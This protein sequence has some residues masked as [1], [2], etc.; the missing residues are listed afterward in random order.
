MTVNSTD[1]LKWREVYS[2]GFLNVAVAISWIAYHEYQPILMT[3][4]GITHLVDFML[5][6]KAIVLVI[7]PPVAGLIADYILKKNGKY[8]IVFTV[9]IGATAMVFMVVASLISSAH[10]MDMR[11]ILPVMIV[12]WLICMNLFVSPANSMIEAFAPVK[13]LP[14]VMG[15]LF[16]VTELVYALEPVIVSLVL[17]FGDTLTF[18]VGGV[19]I[20]VSGY[21]FH[22]VSRDEVLER[23]SQLLV[24]DRVSGKQ[25]IIS[26]LSILIIGLFLGI[27]KAF[28]IEFIPHHI[29]NKFPEFGEYGGYVSF[30][31]LGLCAIGGFLVSRK[32]AQLQLSKVIATSFVILTVGVMFLLFSPSIEL[33]LGGILI[34]AVGFTL[35]NISGLPFA[36]QNLSVRHVTYGV[37]IY[38]GASELLTGVFEYVLQ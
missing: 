13:K 20:A 28:I 12:L 16:L 2:L 34:T 25:A 18:I 37:G 21:I 17:F 15:F 1:Q 29:G 7:I 11:T 35:I 24:A 30:G 27:G 31:T 19:L 36:I 14:I 32:I 5:I 9:G 26:Y 6:A 10:L 38:L 3:N 23:K 33:L 8:L 22:R 4:L